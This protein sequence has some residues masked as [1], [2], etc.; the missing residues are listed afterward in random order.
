MLNVLEGDEGSTKERMV[1]VKV[2][3]VPRGVSLSQKRVKFKILS[4]TSATGESRPVRI[5]I[6]ESQWGVYTSTHIP[7]I[8]HNIKIM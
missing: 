2:I 5:V 8:L 3:D 6:H 7:L 1:C 4:S